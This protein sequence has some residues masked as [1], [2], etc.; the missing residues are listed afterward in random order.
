[1]GRVVGIVAIVMTAVA[2][3]SSTAGKGGDGTTT[4][5]TSSAAPITSEA[6]TTSGV[7]APATSPATTEPPTTPAPAPPP[8][9]PVPGVVTI[10]YAGFGGGSGE[11]QVDWNAATGATSYRVYRGLTT[12]GPWTLMATYDVAS[13]TATT[14]AGVLAVSSPEPG[15]FLYLDL[16]QGPSG[17]WVRVIAYNAAGRG[18]IGE[19][20]CITDAYGHANCP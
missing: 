8:A 20:R 3:S 2:C 13:G 15:K 7:S 11:A 14:H 5:P 10:T 18:P 17:T 1:M 19:T 9:G 4:A 12:S 16:D 6:P